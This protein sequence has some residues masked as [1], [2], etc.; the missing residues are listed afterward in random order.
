MHTIELIFILFMLIFQL[1]WKV[2]GNRE[3]LHHALHCLVQLASLNGVILVNRTARLNYLVKY[4]ECL[5][6]LLSRYVFTDF[7]YAFFF[8]IYSSQLI[9]KLCCHSSN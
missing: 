5:F 9:E 1:Y 8:L 2:R 3:L 6:T 4:L 7:V